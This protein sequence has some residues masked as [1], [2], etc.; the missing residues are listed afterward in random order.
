M[1]GVARKT[2]WHGGLPTS[3]DTISKRRGAR[4]T[5][6]DGASAND[7]TR[8][9][10]D[11]ARGSKKEP[12]G[13]RLRIA[14]RKAARALTRPEPAPQP[15]K[16]RRRE[17]GVGRHF[18][19]A[20]KRLTRWPRPRDHSAPAWIPERSATSLREADLEKTTH[21]LV[22]G[23]IPQR[24]SMRFNETGDRQSQLTSPLGV[25][26][27]D[28]LAQTS[29]GDGPQI[30]RAPRSLYSSF[31]K[32]G[33]CK[34]APPCRRKTLPFGRLMRCKRKHSLQ[35]RVRTPAWSASNPRRPGDCF[36][37]GAS[38]RTRFEQGFHCPGKGH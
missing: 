23:A 32:S 31:E 1:A 2:I 38:S 24:D 11:M 27:R 25:G 17:E 34:M 19:R 18:A 20:A 3:S 12:T 6:R 28:W 14:W 10:T 8:A 29:R 22:A 4:T 7:S 36:L 15:E 21:G 16:R 9:V 35:S 33:S 13:A 5:T 37:P 26:N 30:R